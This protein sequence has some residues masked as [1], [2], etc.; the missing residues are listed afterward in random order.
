MVN[1]LVETVRAGGNRS[2][3]VRGERGMGKT[4]LLEYAAEQAA[5]C[6]VLRVTGHQYEAR[7][8]FAGLHQLCAPLLPFADALTVPQR[9]A[10]HLAFGLS[11]GPEPDRFHIGL[12]VL[13]LLAKAT[14]ERPLLCVVDD[15]Q[16]LD[17]ASARVLGFVAR[18]LGEI[19]VGL[20]FGTRA[21]HD[22]LTGLDDLRLTGLPDPDARALL[23]ATMPGPLDE[24]VRDHIIA[25]TGGNPAELLGITRGLSPVDLAGGFGLPGALAPELHDP[26]VDDLTADARTLLT[27]AAADPTGETSLVLRAAMRSGLPLHTAPRA[28]EKAGLAVFADRIRFCDPRL[29]SSV[30]HAATDQDRRAA[31]RALAD[32][33]IDADWRAWH[34]ALSVVEPDEE[35]ASD[36]VRAAEQARSRGGP[37]AASA[38]F[39]RA[40][41]LTADPE[42]RVA[43]LLSAAEHGLRCGAFDSVR[44]HSHLVLAGPLAEPHAA[45]LEQ[46][47]GRAAFLTGQ[48]GAAPGLLLSAAERLAPHDRERARDGYLIAWTAALYVGA[49]TDGPGLK[50]IS[51]AARTL[52]AASRPAL[53]DRL[54][55][56]LA[57]LVLDGSRSAL[58]RLREVTDAF[59]ATAAGTSDELRWGWPVQAAAGAL[60][61][62]RG[63]L[64]M[65]TRQ[66]GLARANGDVHQLPIVLAEL[67]TL[68]AWM[69]EV[70]AA[71]RLAVES[72]T[73]TAATEMRLA[74]YARIAMAGLR[75]DPALARPHFR[76]GAYLGRSHGQEVAM[77]AV[78]W[79]AA[80]LRNGLGDHDRALPHALDAAE[81]S[82]ALF[83]SLWA[84]PEAVEAAVRSG[85]PDVARKALDRLVDAAGPAGTD[86]A[87]GL[88]ARCRALVSEGTTTEGC[89]HEAIARLERAGLR[90]DHA[91]A[92]LL[93]GEWLHAAGRPAEARTELH[94]AHD[95][96]ADLGMDAFAERARREL[97]ACGGRA[98]RRP[99]DATLTDQ[100][101]QVARLA[102]DGHTNAEIGA[103]MFISARTVEWHLRKIFT[104]L[105]ISSRKELKG[106]LSVPASHGV[107]AKGRD[108]T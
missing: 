11:A 18:R 3:A 59:T 73:A 47:R 95:A 45:R 97:S 80:V 60:W 98:R 69:G 71:E 40:A 103:Q 99:E 49:L 12:A 84:L 14:A 21:D 44:D 108:E 100:E 77:T 79:A 86:H 1:D 10:L 19:P 15:H 51:A 82:P 81:T 57:A 54:L 70:A 31:H 106:V 72:E 8:A 104:K 89:H 32:A 16:W 61:D 53:P 66:A 52:P 65:L 6:R 58:P 74:P 43:W 39:G 17:R 36:L 28:V 27:L 64:G 41:A 68:R 30:Y 34:R 62:P 2:L 33:V 20:V 76:I 7:L 37:A 75:G 48:G 88:I 105:N 90:P 91:R 29:R 92:R 13:A 85:R 94:A 23:A 101:A 87:D 50:E 38:F 42:R 22:E 67:G 26:R 56:A 4:T 102:L 35:A 93:Y 5:G 63:W 55:D 9:E 96:L 107:G 24:R 78:N 46:V 83:L 25:E